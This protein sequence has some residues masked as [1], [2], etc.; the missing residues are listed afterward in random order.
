MISEAQQSTLKRLAAMY[1]KTAEDAGSEIRH[2]EIGRDDPAYK[3]LRTMSSSGE[4]AG[5]LICTLLIVI[6]AVDEAQDELY[7]TGVTCGQEVRA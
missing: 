5:R 3:L 7:P 2:G 1:K 6:Q 4:Y